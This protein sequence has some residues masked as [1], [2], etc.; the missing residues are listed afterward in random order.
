MKEKG[1]IDD[2]CLHCGKPLPNKVKLPY[3]TLAEYHSV[4]NKRRKKSHHRYLFI[5]VL[6]FSLISSAIS[7]ALTARVAQPK[8]VDLCT[9]SNLTIHSRIL[10]TIIQ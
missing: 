2:K 8:F 4:I 1:I 3:R 9:E 6:I 7:I 5:I 10:G